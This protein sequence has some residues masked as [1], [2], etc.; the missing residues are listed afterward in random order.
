M[1]DR[2]FA[3]VVQVVNDYSVAINEG[4]SAGVKEGDRFLLVRL[5]DVIIDPDTQ[6]ELERLELVIGECIARH[7]QERISTIES[8]L[9]TKEPDKKEVHRVTSKGGGLAALTGLH[10]LNETVKTTETITPGQEY[11][12]KL[13]SPEIG[14][15]VIRI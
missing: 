6:E 10:G 1:S 12:K 2:Y 5:G 14:D 11:L 8:C 9:K 4:A 15:V 3:K 7:V 13:K